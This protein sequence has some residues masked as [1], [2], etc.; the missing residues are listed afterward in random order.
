MHV[1]RITHAGGG[2]A[3]GSPQPGWVLA[4]AV[5]GDEAG[6]GWPKGHVLSAGDLAR[7]VS[8]PW[9]EL[10]LIEPDPDD[11]HEVE[12]GRRIAA[13]ARGSGVE[14]GALSGGHWPLVATC[15][16]VLRV[17]IA[18][19]T[20]VNDV[21]G[22]CVYSRLHGQPVDAGAVVARAKVTPLVLS[23]GAV[24]EAERVARDVGGL[25]RVAPFRRQQIA[26]VV[27]ERLDAHAVT[28]F[29]AALS[30]KLGWLGSDLLAPSFVPPQVTP[31]VHALERAAAAGATIVLMAGSKALDPLDPAFVALAHLG[32]SLDR[33]GVPVHPGSLFWIARWGERVILGVPTCGLF[34]QLT[35]FDVIL[36]RI[37]AD[38]L[39][40][41]HTLSALGHG[42]LLTGGTSFF[43][44]YAA[45]AYG[46][47]D[48][49]ATESRE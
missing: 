19:L 24:A 37:L 20:A 10:H 16:G 11:V 3:G 45:G 34:S 14:V 49:R 27:Q 9:D 28:R 44:P 41:T 7:L 12:A 40:D 30:D 47:R 26:A 6:G 22:A 25:V 4:Q 35:S 17:E 18:A 1:H 5:E 32:V 15:R 21:S 23:A 43:P 8:A 33:Y 46:A 38:Q 31:I 48:S 42:G 36:P 2:Y 29:T 39:M 13:A